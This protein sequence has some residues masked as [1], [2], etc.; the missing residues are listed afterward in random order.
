MTEG[1]AVIQANALQSESEEQE[2]DGTLPNPCHPFA[3]SSSHPKAPDH[4]WVVPRPT[5]AYYPLRC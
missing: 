2:T 3:T 4:D 5:Q 1:D